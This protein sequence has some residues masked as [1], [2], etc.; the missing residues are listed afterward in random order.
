[1][2]NYSDV[3]AID[4]FEQ[5]GPASYIHAVRELLL[6]NK[7]RLLDQKAYLDGWRGFVYTYFSAAETFLSHIKTNRYR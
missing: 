6:E 2:I 5:E 1:L 3:R 7:Q 4:I